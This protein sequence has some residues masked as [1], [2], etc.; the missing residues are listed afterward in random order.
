MIIH[1]LFNNRAWN[2]SILSFFI[3]YFALSACIYTEVSA[4]DFTDS[5]D[6]LFRQWNRNNSPGC[7]LAIVRDGEILYKKAYGMSNL[8]YDLPNTTT[9]IFRAGSN[10]KQFTAFAILLLEEEGLVGL[11][12]DVRMYVPEVPDFG[13]TITLRHLLH[14]ISGLR[15]F[16]ELFAFSGRHIMADPVDKEQ[17]FALISR[18]KKLNFDPGEQFIYSNT[19]YF[20]LAEIVARVSGKSFAE[21]VNERIFEPLGMTHS[22]F[23]DNYLAIVKNFADP[24]APNPDGGFLQMSI[25]TS[26]VGAEGLLTTVE[27]LAKWDQNF[28]TPIVGS[29]RILQKMHQ[30]AILNNGTQNPYAVGIIVDE[31]KGRKLVFHGGD[32]GGYHGNIVRFPE[33][34]FSILTLSNNAD[35]N[36]GVLLEK[37]LQIA[38]LHFNNPQTPVTNFLIHEP[39]LSRWGLDLD[40]MKAFDLQRSSSLQTMLQT[41]RKTDAD[42][43]L[44]TVAPQITEEAAQEYVGRYYSEE[45]EVFYTIT[46]EGDLLHFK[47]PITH[48]VTEFTSRLVRRDR[49]TFVESDLLSGNFLRNVAGEVIGF[50]ISNPRV[51]NLEF[52]K[53]EI[54][55]KE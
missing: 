24:Y 35:L 39:S 18:Q 4:S 51:L 30:K 8:R 10:S 47:F 31:Y 16:Y 42:D 33:E 41:S 19:G 15:D 38:D 28:Y 14:H 20:L 17:T 53:A 37:S 5:V 36:S 21:F 6:R 22:Q 49:I 13:K 3:I 12:D 40:F 46:Y 34:H 9:T 2:Q 27:D 7:T 23:R 52:R 11:D 50:Q 1:S 25:N 32:I 55:M 43:F 45:L 26:T 54:V 48:L 29:Q 44:K